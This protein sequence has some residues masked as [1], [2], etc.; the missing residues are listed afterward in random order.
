[1]KIEHGLSAPQWAWE[2]QDVSPT[3]KLVLLALASFQITHDGMT[4]PSKAEIARRCCIKSP[5]TINAAISGLEGKGL[6]K[7]YGRRDER[8][9]HRSNIYHLNMEAQT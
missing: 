3:E 9:V 4:S 1:M 8:G 7:V 2:A 5:R 6:I